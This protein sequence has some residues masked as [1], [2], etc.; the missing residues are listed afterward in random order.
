MM[1]LFLLWKSWISVGVRA[2]SSTSSNCT[3][4][5]AMLPP[6]DNKIFLNK[7]GERTTFKV[8]LHGVGQI[9]CVA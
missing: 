6:A 3:V 5:L 9:C 2:A 7:T 4:A 1:D 8:F